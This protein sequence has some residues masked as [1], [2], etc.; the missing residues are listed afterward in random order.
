M[1]RHVSS[2]LERAGTA[3]VEPQ[4]PGERYVRI[5]R[6]ACSTRAK[7]PAAM[8]AAAEVPPCRS[9]QLFFPTSVVC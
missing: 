6:L 1:S 2:G 4:R 5:T 3:S 9:V 8:G 7:I